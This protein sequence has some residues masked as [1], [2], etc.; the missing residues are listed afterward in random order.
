MG[1]TLIQGIIQQKAAIRKSWENGGNADENTVNKENLLTAIQ[2]RIFGNGFVTVDVVIYL[3]V[4][5]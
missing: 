1:K 2:T 4:V 3:S 5:V